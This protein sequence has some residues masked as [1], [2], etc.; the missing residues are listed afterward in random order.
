MSF[1]ER[2]D[3]YIRGRGAD[4]SLFAGLFAQGS[5]AGAFPHDTGVYL[6]KAYGLALVPRESRRDDLLDRLL[7]RS[8]G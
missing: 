4:G 8:G 6:E 5:Y 1:A 7:E 2:P 3:A